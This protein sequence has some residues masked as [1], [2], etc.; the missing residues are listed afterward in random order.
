M[1]TKN[2][3]SLPLREKRIR[4]TLLI[5]GCIA[6]FLIFAFFV[7]VILEWRIQFEEGIRI[8]VFIQFG[9]SL[10]VLTIIGLSIPLI[11]YDG[12]DLKSKNAPYLIKFAITALFDVI[13]LG[14]GILLFVSFIISIDSPMWQVSSIYVSLIMATLIWIMVDNYFALKTGKKDDGLLVKANNRWLAINSFIGILPALYGI[15]ETFFANDRIVMIYKNLVYPILL[16]T[17]IVIFISLLLYITNICL[18]KQEKK[19]KKLV[20]W[21]ILSALTLIFLI[22]FIVKGNMPYSV[23][24][25][26]RII[27]Q[28]VPILYGLSMPITFF[29]VNRKEKRQMKTK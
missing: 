3:S 7:M 11:V 19:T 18:S 2:I 24:A 26:L 9:L 12:K 25:Y 14:L 20:V 15:V 8:C 28:M 4:K 21:S 27:F 17:F 29:C 16:T 5:F 23:R 1:E 10:I 22:M 6:F 13:I